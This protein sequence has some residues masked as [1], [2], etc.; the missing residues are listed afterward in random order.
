VIQWEWNEKRSGDHTSGQGITLHLRRVSNCFI[1]PKPPADWAYCDDR[2]ISPWGRVAITVPV[3]VF[4]YRTS[5]SFPAWLAKSFS[6]TYSMAQ[7][8]QA[9]PELDE[10]TSVYEALSPSVYYAL[11]LENVERILDSERKRGGERFEFLGLKFPASNLA[12]W[13][14]WLIVLLQLYLWI[15]LKTFRQTLV[16]SESAEPAWSVPWIGLYRDGTS[17]AVSLATLT[18][19]PTLVIVL[20]GWAGMN[21]DLWIILFLASLFLFSS[22]MAFVTARELTRIWRLQNG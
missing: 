5:Q 11:S 9:F 19:L 17:K 6:R 21:Q 3:S 8:R 1:K 18:L 12:K 4:Y 20:L 7:F 13:G 10:I 2:E 14:P 22:L 15:N 16:V